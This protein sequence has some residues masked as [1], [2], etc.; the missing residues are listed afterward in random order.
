AGLGLD[1]VLNFDLYR[2]NA[3]A[4]FVAVILIAAALCLFM[5][6]QSGQTKTMPAMRG[7]HTRAKIVFSLT[8]GLLGA[9]AVAGLIDALG[10]DVVPMLVELGVLPPPN[11][12]FSRFYQPSFAP[13]DGILSV[14]SL[15][16]LSLLILP[17]AAVAFFLMSITT[18]G[19]DRYWQVERWTLLLTLAGLGLVVFS[20]VF[21]EEDAYSYYYHDHFLGGCYSAWF[22]G[23][24]VL[25]FGWTCRTM[26]LMMMR[27]YEKA[28]ADSD[29][30]ICFACGYDLRILTGETCPECGTPVSVKLLAK[31]RAIADE[32]ARVEADSARQAEAVIEELTR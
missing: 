29:E 16:S 27:Q 9:S 10:V 25:T 3:E 28:I 12:T 14:V 18:L 7:M 13:S 19:R 11:N 1:G 24:A 23:W 31:R 2:H 30:P 4:A 17:T 6:P 8:I 26:L 32:Q 5:I 15:I 22:V 21:V 20:V